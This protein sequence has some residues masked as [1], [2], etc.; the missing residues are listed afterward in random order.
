MRKVNRYLS[1]CCN[2]A[3]TGDVACP[4]GLVAVAVP[5]GPSKVSTLVG[6]YLTSEF[7]YISPTVGYIDGQKLMI[8]VGH[9]RVAD[10]DFVFG[11]ISRIHCANS[12]QDFSGEVN[13]CFQK[14]G[15]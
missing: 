14:S 13:T 10:T 2:V 6:Q 1:N 7:S 4:V 15:A 5:A 11:D 12:I 3:W 8:V 9:N